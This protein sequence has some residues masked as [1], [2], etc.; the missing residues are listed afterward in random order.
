MFQQDLAKSADALTLFF[1]R[2]W[3]QLLLTANLRCLSF[4]KVVRTVRT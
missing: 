3:Q 1:V 2:H 4:M